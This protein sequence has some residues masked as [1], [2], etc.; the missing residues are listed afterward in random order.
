MKVWQPRVQWVLGIAGVL[1]LALNGCGGGSDETAAETV[2][3]LTK[4]QLGE[5]LGDICQEHTDR[6]V[7]AIET[8][9][10]SEPIA[11]RRTAR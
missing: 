6:Q 8:W 1:L 3:R 11:R 10:A 7:V 5:K 9:A 4:A 2:P